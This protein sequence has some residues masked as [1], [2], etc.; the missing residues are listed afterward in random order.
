[1]KLNA[2]FRFVVHTWSASTSRLGMLAH[3]PLKSN[4]RVPDLHHRGFSH[5]DTIMR[6]DCRTESLAQGILLGAQLRRDV[7]ISL[8]LVD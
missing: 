7:S 4:A 5:D 8:A 6:L 2:A 1:M 3:L